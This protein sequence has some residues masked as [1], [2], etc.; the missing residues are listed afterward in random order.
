M[1]IET[2]AQK[3]AELWRSQEVENHALGLS[4]LQSQ[5]E[6]W[7]KERFKQLLQ[8]VVYHCINVPEFRDGLKFSNYIEKIKTFI[9]NGIDTTNLK[10]FIKKWKVLCQLIRPQNQRV[11]LGGHLN[12]KI[13]VEPK[14]E[15]IRQWRKKMLRTEKSFR[16]DAERLKEKAFKSFLE[17]E[18]F[19]LT[20]SYNLNCLYKYFGCGF[21]LSNFKDYNFADSLSLKIDTESAL[22]AIAQDI[23]DSLQ[24]EGIYD[25]SACALIDDDLPF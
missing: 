19:E 4:F 24:C 7:D 8:R 15:Y 13:W 14:N 2:M 11:E 22:Q 9:T 16:G 20:I 3:I 18:K 10:F 5:T 1:D 21:C 23:A 17:P 12:L 25:E 6:G